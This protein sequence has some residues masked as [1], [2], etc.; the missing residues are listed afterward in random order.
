MGLS[1]D[2]G[3]DVWASEAWRE[4]AVSWLDASLAAAGLRRVGD[5][6]QPHLR[7]WGT[8]LKV[9][10]TGGPVWLKAAGPGTSF[11]VGLY[12]ILHR[13]APG[14]VLT[15][16]AADAERGWIALPDG[17]PALGERAAGADLVNALTVALPQYGQ[18]QRDLAPRVGDLL[19]L[20]VTDMRAAI[21]PARFDEALGA[22]RGYA[23]STGTADEQ[24]AFA[25]LAPL[26]GTFVSWCDRLAASPVTPSLDHNDLHA[27][28]V[29]MPGTGGAA[30]ARF[31]DWGDSV[32]AHPFASMLIGLG[33][34]RYH[35]DVRDDDPAILRLRDAY[36][37]AFSDLAP[38]AELVTVLE[39]ACRVGKVARALTWHRATTALGDGDRSDFAS[40]PLRCLCSLLA[41]S[42][43]GGA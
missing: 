23:A 28:N 36:L 8:V 11:E 32:V 25:R 30:R 13:V 9:P 1:R 39:L 5:A 20:G 12:E 38:R 18:L 3:V 17:G 29:L 41:E 33:F 6:E 19:A 24:A 15:P 40:A 7:P 22:V 27:W 16:I 34:M 35:L 37:E 14:Q 43:L 4:R 10:T 26:R 42:Y 2:T 21:M 31:Y